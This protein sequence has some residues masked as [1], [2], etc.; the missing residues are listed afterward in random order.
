MNL[1]DNINMAPPIGFEPIISQ[2]RRLVFSPLNYEG[3]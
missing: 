3:I 2:F 1:K